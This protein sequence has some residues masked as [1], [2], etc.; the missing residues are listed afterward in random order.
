MKCS[1][2]PPEPGSYKG[3]PGRE[4]TNHTGIAK[5]AARHRTGEN[6]GRYNDGKNTACKHPSCWRNQHGG[7]FRLLPV[8]KKRK[9]KKKKKRWRIH[10][11]MNSEWLHCHGLLVTFPLG[12]LIFRCAMH[13]TD[14]EGYT[15]F[16]K[17]K[18]PQPLAC[19]FGEAIM[20]SWPHKTLVTSWP[21][22]NSSHTC[23]VAGHT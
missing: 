14:V 8:Q 4:R 23:H 18:R 5:T 2:E 22:I 16:C 10:D 3:K 7:V 1:N 19:S 9:E 21:P 6:H 17:I 20:I 11:S 13:A 12:C 15:T